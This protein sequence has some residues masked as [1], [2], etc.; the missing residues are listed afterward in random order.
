MGAHQVIACLGLS[1]RF[2]KHVEAAH[3]ENRTTLLLASG[4]A[5]LARRTHGSFGKT[6]LNRA[7]SRRVG[8]EPLAAAFIRLHIGRRH[9]LSICSD[10]SIF[11]VNFAAVPLFIDNAMSNAM[12]H[13]GKL[14]IWSGLFAGIRLANMTN[15]LEFRSRSSGRF[16]SRVLLGS[17]SRKSGIDYISGHGTTLSGRPLGRRG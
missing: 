8:L 13:H 17:E 10:R 11:V 4:S 7:W 14:L 2:R 1:L 16:G 5:N 6:F 3:A 15:G 9:I 12:S